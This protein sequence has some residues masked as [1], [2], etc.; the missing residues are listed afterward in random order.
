MRIAYWPSV[1]LIL[2]STF[3]FFI[4]RPIFIISTFCTVIYDE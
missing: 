2:I 4:I 3:V 1:C